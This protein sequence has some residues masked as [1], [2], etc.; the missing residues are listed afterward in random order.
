[1]ESGRV[2]RRVT[3]KECKRLKAQVEDGGFKAQTKL[4]HTA[5]KRMLEDRA[6][7]PEGEEYMTRIQGHALRELPQKLVER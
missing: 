6:A 3:R 7:L 2:T 1:M 4:W 5:E